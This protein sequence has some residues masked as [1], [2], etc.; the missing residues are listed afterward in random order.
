MDKYQKAE[1]F[2]NYLANQN[3]K[4]FYDFTEKFLQILYPSEEIEIK[5]KLKKD[6]YCIVSSILFKP[7]HIPLDTVIDSKSILNSD[8]VNYSKELK[9]LSKFI[10]ITNNSHFT[11]SEEFKSATAKKYPNLSFEL[12][13]H[14]VLNQK[15]ITLSEESLNDLLGEFQLFEDYKKEYQSF[16]EDRDI[17]KELFSF[18]LKK[19]TQPE[20]RRN[21]EPEKLTHIKDK[22]VLNFSVHQHDKVKKSFNNLYHLV[23]QT[24]T[25]IKDQILID[26]DSI[27]EL[28]E[29]IQSEYCRIGKKGDVNCA[30][31]DHLIIDEVARTLLTDGR[32]NHTRFLNAAKAVVLF[33]F[34]YCDIGRKTDDE[35][36]QKE[37]DLFDDGI[38]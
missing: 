32:T 11:I 21:V 25:F 33:F 4:T 12:W 35:V 19:N 13:N 24:E 18:I 8:V 31:N 23:H 36:N 9:G 37:P 10:Y 30:I 26:E 22:I 34:V 15:L 1:Q 7:F 6:S 17:L 27:Y 20:V 14:R 38:S 28:K 2:V 5:T 3:A 16:E 29:R